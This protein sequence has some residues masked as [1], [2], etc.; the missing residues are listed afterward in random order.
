MTIEDA[1]I[2]D[3]GGRILFRAGP[4]WIGPGDRVVVLGSNGSGKTRLI[5]ALIAALG[6]ERPGIRVAASVVAG[7]S[8]QTLSQLDRYASPLDAVTRD[9]DVGDRAARAMLAGAGTDIAFQDGPIAALSSGQ[10][11][12]LAMLLLRLE[13]PN[14]HV[15]DE[16]TN[17]LDI[18]GQEALE[19]ELVKDRGTAI[20]VSHDRAF[21]RN[22]GTRF[23]LIGAG[24]LDEVESP[25]PFFDAQL[26][27]A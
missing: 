15:L 17:H 1:A 26:A 23:W 20:L 27:P 3:P 11:A 2:T 25:E 19:R 16:P 18:E 5:S 4:L 7:V 14:L 24:R 13:R 6:A 10:R 9:R 8:D 22:V 12:R 21:V